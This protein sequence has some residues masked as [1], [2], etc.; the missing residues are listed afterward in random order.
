MTTAVPGVVAV[1]SGSAPVFAAFRIPREGL[2]LGRNLVPG[3]DARISTRH[4]MVTLKRDGIFVADLG[5]RNGTFV[6]GH[7]VTGELRPDLLPAVVRTGRSLFVVVADVRPYEHLAITHRGELVV[8]ATLEP[9]L[10][11]LEA[12]VLAEQHVVFVGTR[13]VGR[14]L[15]KLYA[16]QRAGATATYA[17]SAIDSSLARAITLAPLPL[18]TIILDGLPRDLDRDTLA[19]WLARDVR[20]ATAVLDQS[21]LIHLPAQ[22]VARTILVPWPRFDELPTTLFDAAAGFPLHATVIERMLLD[23]WRTPE[24]ALLA[25]LRGDLA[26]AQA[27]HRKEL[28]GE[29]LTEATFERQGHGP[30]IAM[31]RPPTQSES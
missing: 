13:S 2:V 1:W 28:R 7:T 26:R 17:A 8:A 29:D 9:T 12:A 6:A 4:A 23:A 19:T 18:R 21:E 16:V 14:Q 22:L 24:D 30:R 11:A 5:S 15:A 3:A 25:W 20:F 31:P 27:A 10:R